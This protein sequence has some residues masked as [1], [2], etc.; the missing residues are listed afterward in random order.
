MPPHHPERCQTRAQTGPS[1]AAPAPHLG[2]IVG[3]GGCACLP[4]L[5][6]QPRL[7]LGH[8]IKQVALGQG[9]AVAG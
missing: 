5:R 6:I 2:A 9:C 3:I 1:P 7:L 4:Q 8:S